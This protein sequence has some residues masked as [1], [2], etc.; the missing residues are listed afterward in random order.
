MMRQPTTAHNDIPTVASLHPS[1]RPLSVHLSITYRHPSVTRRPLV[2]V[3]I[4]GY[5]KK[6]EKR[7][8]QQPIQSPEAMVL[9]LLGDS[10]I[11]G[12]SGVVLVGESKTRIRTWAE[13][14]WKVGGVRCPCV[15][16]PA[17]SSKWT[18]SV[19]KATTRNTRHH[20]GVEHQGGD[21]NHGC[22]TTASKGFQ[23][24]EAKWAMDASRRPRHKQEPSPMER[25]GQR[26]YRKSNCLE[27]RGQPDPLAVP[28]G[29]SFTA[30]ESGTT[31]FAFKIPAGVGRNSAARTHPNGVQ[32]TRSGLVRAHYPDWA[33]DALPAGH[34]AHGGVF[35]RLLPVLH[36]NVVY[37]PLNFV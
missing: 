9:L 29:T 10:Y 36:V 6:E 20:R 5:S 23:R 22:G 31:A 12:A 35:T 34:S 13:L 21:V 2:V 24:R 15:C 25:P 37:Q 17:H 26:R 3:A 27:P 30:W 19:D 28:R 4:P 7:K 33:S 18:T 8:G 1:I 32:I 14:R 11:A 16:T